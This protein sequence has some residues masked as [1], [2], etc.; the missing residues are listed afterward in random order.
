MPASWDSGLQ[1]ERT[2]LAWLRTSLAT[3]ACSLAVI[4]L[5][6]TR[7]HTLAGLI[8]LASL[9]GSAISYVASWAGYRRVVA[10]LL[11]ASP[12]TRMSTLVASIVAIFSTAAA[13]FLLA[14]TS[15]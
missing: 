1:P 4:R 9:A 13:A 12:I 6:V 2:A 11:T 5:A 7:D 3:A 14:L 8:G 10:E 15:S